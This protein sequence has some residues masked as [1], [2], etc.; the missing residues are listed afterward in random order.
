MLNKGVT[1]SIDKASKDAGKDGKTGGLP[2]G[3]SL[4]TVSKDVL[5]STGKSTI[6]DGRLSTRTR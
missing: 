1:S 4:P 2:F 6:I 3:G 5:K